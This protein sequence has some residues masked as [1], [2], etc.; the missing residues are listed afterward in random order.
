MIL[1]RNKKKNKEDRKEGGKRDKGMKQ[2]KQKKNGKLKKE[3]DG[4]M[5]DHING[6]YKR[7]KKGE[8]RRKR[9]EKKNLRKIRTN[10]KRGEIQQRIIRR[11]E[12]WKRK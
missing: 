6:Y 10:K 7:Q 8:G 12:K 3:I 9:G 1:R 11:K 4:N 2:G 5:I